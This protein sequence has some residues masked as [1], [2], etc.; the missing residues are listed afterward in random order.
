MQADSEKKI[1]AI[2]IDLQLT[3][4]EDNI[5][6]SIDN[7][8]II[9]QGSASEYKLSLQGGLQAHHLILLLAEYPTI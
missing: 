6:L 5:I 3:V 1:K 2:D 4:Q 8:R 9:R 7:K